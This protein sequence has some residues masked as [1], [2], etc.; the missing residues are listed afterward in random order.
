MPR[1]SLVFYKEIDGTVPVLEWLN[2]LRHQQRKAWAN[3]LARIERL[4]AAG[5]ELRRPEADILRD[6]IYELRAKHGHVQY[7]VL[8]FFHGRNVA[9]L[10]HSIL[11]HGSVVPPSDIERAIKRKKAFEQRPALHSHYNPEEQ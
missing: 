6:G 11:K 8:Y 10:A 3:C 7:R 4:G 2:E 9:V 1:T 5:F